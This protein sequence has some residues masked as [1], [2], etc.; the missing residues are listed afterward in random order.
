MKKILIAALLCIAITSGAT[1]QTTNIKSGTN[2]ISIAGMRFPLNS[3]VLQVS[4]D[5]IHVAF[6]NM[7]VYLTGYGD[8]IARMD[9]FNHYLNNGTAFTSVSQIDSF[10]Q[11]KFVK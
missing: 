5:S 4:P 11:A 9:S 10:Y 1:A 3:I 2:S 8:P 6:W 7:Q